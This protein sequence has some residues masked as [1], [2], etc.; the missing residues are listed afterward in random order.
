MR[1]ITAQAQQFLQA[2]Q[3][4]NARAAASVHHPERT[5]GPTTIEISQPDV[6]EQNSALQLRVRSVEDQYLELFS[7]HLH[8]V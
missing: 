4:A 6:S 8:K 7:N 3:E 1:A 5:H 2:G